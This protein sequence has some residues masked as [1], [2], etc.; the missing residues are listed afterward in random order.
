MSDWFSD[1]APKAL[2]LF[3]DLQRRMTPGEKILNV[4]RAIELIR[5]MAEADVR[6]LHP[7]ADDREVFLQVAS[8]H[9]DRETM[10][11]VYD[12]APKQ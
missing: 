4:F 11:R 1:T 2:E 10:R 8:R 9:L 5:A 7:D 3:L 12:W 6:R